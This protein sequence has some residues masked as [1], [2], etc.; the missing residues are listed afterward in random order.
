MNSLP[1][2]VA[3]ASS[4]LGLLLALDALFT[5]EQARRLGEQRKR[6]G[7]AER[8]AL[9]TIRW[10]TIG[11]AVVTATAIVALAPT[12]WDV[13]AAIGD[14][15]WEPVLSVFELAWVLLVALVVWQAAIAWRTRQ[16]PD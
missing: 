7:G 9:R 3:Q 13:L 11:L 10:L 4:L 1:D 5:S 8:D 14:P 2:Q 15:G 12:V 6:A 16:P